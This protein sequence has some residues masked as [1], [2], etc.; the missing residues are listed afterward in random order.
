MR[1]IFL[2][3]PTKTD[4]HKI[5]QKEYRK[6]PN[7]KP[8][9]FFPSA[10][11]KKQE[12]GNQT[13]HQPVIPEH[14]VRIEVDKALAEQKENVKRIVVQVKTQFPVT[15]DCSSGMQKRLVNAA[16]KHDGK[17]NGVPG[18]HKKHQVL[19]CF[20]P[21]LNHHDDQE[22]NINKKNID[23]HVFQHKLNADT[24]EEIS[25][26]GNP[27]KTGHFIQ[28]NP[29]NQQLKSSEEEYGKTKV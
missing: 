17:T 14:T 12:D 4:K 7:P 20:A 11:Q 19:C 22:K 1:K 15:A 27:G 18:K 9:Q 3:R 13:A 5:Q 21:L 8:D 24:E 26:P 10:A 6:N 28:Y 29:G 16:G 25:K 2:Q 23:R